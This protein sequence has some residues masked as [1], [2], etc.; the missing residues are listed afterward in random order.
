M[1]VKSMG[2]H[3][4]L[5]YHSCLPSLHTHLHNGICQ[6]AGAM[7]WR[8]ETAGISLIHSLPV[9]HPPPSIRNDW[10]HQIQGHKKINSEASTWPKDLACL[11]CL[12]GQVSRPES[13]ITNTDQVIPVWTHSIHYRSSDPKEEP[14]AWHW[15]YNYSSWVMSYCVCFQEAILEFW[16]RC[17]KSHI[18]IERSSWIIHE[19]SG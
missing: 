11:L 9:I 18:W 8:R 17:P 16:R 12:A 5:Y 2:Y 15:P 6:K 4:I 7:G 19:A 13:Q 14:I 10:R 1:D 3:W